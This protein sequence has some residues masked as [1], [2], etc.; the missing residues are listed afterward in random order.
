MDSLL[1]ILAAAAFVLWLFHG[2]LVTIERAK[3][4]GEYLRSWSSAIIGAAIALF[5]IVDVMPHMGHG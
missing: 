3:A 5:V 2:G 1:L 4:A